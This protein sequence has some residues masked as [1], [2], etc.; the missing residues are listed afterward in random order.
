[1]ELA[2]TVFIFMGE[3]RKAALIAPRIN[4]VT[5]TANKYLTSFLLLKIKNTSAKNK[6]KKP[7]LFQ[8]RSDVIF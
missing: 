5:I 4:V 8:H 6:M 1:V 3:S 7:S 2:A